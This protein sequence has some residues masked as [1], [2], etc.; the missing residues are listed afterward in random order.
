MRE[1]TDALPAADFGKREHMTSTIGSVATSDTGFRMKKKC[2]A[3]AIGTF[4]LIFAGT[5]AIVV[6]DVSNGTIT[7][8]GI[9]IT[10]GLI[11]MSMIYAIG[12]VSGAHIVS[13]RRTAS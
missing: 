9:A 6:N 8:V 3:E 2:V 11:V 10:F 13:A 12:D 5:G 4:G 7:H 1:S